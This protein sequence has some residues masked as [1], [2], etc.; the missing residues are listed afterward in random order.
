MVFHKQDRLLKE[1]AYFFGQHL[2]DY[3]EMLEKENNE[4][5]TAMTC[6]KVKNIHSTELITDDYTSQLMDFV[7]QMEDDSFVHYE[8]FSS[9][10]TE[11]NIIRTGI[12]DMN[13]YKKTKKLVNTV[14]I[15]TGDPNKSITNV[16]FSDNN[17][18]APKKMKFLKNYKGDKRLKNVKNKIKN[19]EKL[20]DFDIL[21]LI[22]LPFLKTTKESEEVIEEICNLAIKI[23]NLTEEHSQILFWGLWL[24]T[25][26]FIQNKN[27]QEKVKTMT[28]INESSINEILL[29]KESKLIQEGIK[30]GKE[31][32]AGN[33][34]K[35]GIPIKQISKITGLNINKIK[36]LKIGK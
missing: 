22:I 33:M 30:E 6:T 26:I 32:I 36:Q 8:H 28:L 11:N 10:L 27:T 17:N 35:E 23:N 16:K 29:K 7:Y 15:S 34:I 21:D 14:I 19:N 25:E 1:L 4:K 9:N 2:F 13:L 31:E 24:T 18:Y 12:N 3:L 5:Y 20:T